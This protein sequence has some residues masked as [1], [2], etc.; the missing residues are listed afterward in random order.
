MVPNVTNL[1]DHLTLTLGQYHYTINLANA[2][3]SIA[4][5]PD[6]QDQFAFTPKDKL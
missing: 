1:I 5:T 2:F 3:F 4:I 6:R